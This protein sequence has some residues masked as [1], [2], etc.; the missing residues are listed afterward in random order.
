M[1]LGSSPKIES[2]WLDGSV[3]NE[4][5]KEA[6][7]HPTGLAVDFN[8]DH[9]VYWTDTKLN[10][11]ES[12]R[13]D[14]SGR[15]VIIRGDYLKHPISLD[16]FESS[17]FWITRDTGEVIKQDK[18]GRGDPVVVAKDLLNP[19]GVKGSTYLLV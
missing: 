18:F 15:H 1:N 16:V 4:V 19:A 2:S 12:M 7:G 9:M 5:I 14:G 3:R 13:P 17:L 11:I 8:M 6:L 10:T